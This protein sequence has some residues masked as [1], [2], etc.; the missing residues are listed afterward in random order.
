MGADWRNRLEDAAAGS[1]ASLAG[2]V[3]FSSA[4]RRI[5]SN[6][7]RHSDKSLLEALLAEMKVRIKVTADDLDRIPRQG[8]ALVVANH[9]FG[10]LDG[11]VLGATLL[12][13]RP[14]V[15]IVTNNLLQ[16]LPELR[17]SCIFVDPFNRRGSRHANAGGL[18]RAISHLRAGG[19][20]AVF[21]AGEV[22][23]WQPQHWEV[24]D[25]EWNPS[26]AML[27]RVSG[28]AVLPAMFLGRNS[29]PFQTLGMIHPLM[30]TLSLPQEFVNKSGHSVDLRVGVAI[31]AERIRRIPNDAAVTTYLRWRTYLLKNRGRH[32]DPRKAPLAFP[33]VRRAPF[34]TV[35]VEVAPSQLLA[36]I[37][38]LAP[39]QI[40]DETR[41][42]SVF[43]TEAMQT[44]ALVLEIGRLREL[45]FRQVGEGTGRERDLD[46]FDHHYKHLVLWHKEKQQIVGAY[47]F[48]NIQEVLRN[49][50]AAGLYTSTLFTYHPRFLQG[51]GPALELGR[52][53][54]RGEYQKHYSP[55]LLLWKGIARYVAAHPETPVL[56]GAVSISNGYEKASREL[57]VQFFQ[58]QPSHP[59]AHLV[60]PKRMFR[61][62]RWR[63]WELQSLRDLLDIEEVS[64]SIANIE[65]DGKGIPV[66]LRQYL[67]LGGELLG[68]NV[69]RNFC[70]VLDGLIVVDLR[71]ADPGRLATYMGQHGLS[72]FRRFHGLAEFGPASSIPQKRWAGT[73]INT[74]LTP[75]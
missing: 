26:V 25:P 3:L 27:A 51:L 33:F 4:I 2:K 9:P 63:S 74:R 36:E 35:A 18:K 1:F 22:S 21:P 40:I 60:R 48:A 28:A 43:M 64:A 7:Q 70:N 11:V 30:R 75:D 19:M 49:Q 54:I 46:T 47:R 50:G 68:F 6:A 16:R 24:T 58:S 34:K 32:Q 52:S 8:P 67:K 44:P 10:I 66:L 57:L 41:D 62:Q 56:F 55:L 15:K 69:D 5:Y 71:K 45:T 31:P 20:V 37:N 13:I 61:P 14:D 39:G 53:F 72:V 42:F 38:A 12:R 29:V 17:Q 23:H 73:E 59:M 65:Q